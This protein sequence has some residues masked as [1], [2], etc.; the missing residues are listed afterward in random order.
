M[1]TFNNIPTTIRTPGTFVE[2]DNSRA[3]KGLVAN[4]HKVL[5]LGQKLSG[6]SNM[7]GT[8][9][10][11]AVMAITKDGLANGYFG[12]GSIL[13]RMC[14]IFKKNNQNTELYAMALS[15]PAGAAAA[16]K[17]IHMS[18]L[19]SFNAG[20]V[21]T[22]N[23]QLHLMINGSSYDLTL[24]SNW[25]VGAVN[26]QLST[27]VNSNA[28]CPFT[29]T[30]DA[31]SAI[32]LTAKIPGEAGNYIDVRFNYFTGQSFPKCMSGHTPSGASKIISQ[33]TSGA[34]NALLA[35]AWAI[36]DGIQYHH[37]VQPYIDAT[38][39]A[40][41]EN[42]LDDRFKP[43]TDLQG[44]GYGCVRGAA[45]SCTTLG[46][47]RNS[48]YNTIMGV[49]DSPS[50]P[51]EWAAAVAAVASFNLNNDPARPLQFLQVKGVLAPP[52][53][54][55]FTRAE[56]D[57]LLYD[58]ISTFIVDSGGNV[59]LERLITTYQRNALGTPDPSY[60]DIETLFTLGEI[61]YQYKS[62]MISRFII[63]RF[64][65]ADDTFPVQPG[66]YVATPKTVKQETIALFSLLQDRGLIENLDQFIADLQ[67][68]R[69][70]ADVNRVNVLLPP[71]LINQFRVL[72]GIVQFIL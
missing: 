25:S 4:P 14:N 21:S 72:A 55:R 51:A 47:S 27:L 11:N 65:L 19:L 58:G 42:E 18:I 7:T 34:S 35:D 26:S 62:R 41:L 61:R 70:I 64:K 60:L 45:A 23:E 9:G 31:A 6:A 33:T 15:T 40:S 28:N 22:N 37:I 49:Y 36:I 59:N 43:L 3:I 32:V 29:L 68:E 39:I 16:V 63:P 20:V 46:N 5:I 66:S 30:T 2:I 12:Q 71:D 48:P 67:V 50:D 24:T 8:A 38:N 52:E 17:C 53:S 69:D 13:A 10:T 54:S 44:H 56:R 1:I 57:V